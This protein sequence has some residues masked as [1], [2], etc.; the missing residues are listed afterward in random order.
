VQAGDMTE[1][2]RN[3]LLVKMTDA[4]GALVLGTNY[5]QTQALSLAQRRARERMAEYKRRM[6]DLEARGK[7]DRALEFLPSD[8]ELA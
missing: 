6:G 8:E 5:K 3:A 4:V 7:L 1:K 2:Q